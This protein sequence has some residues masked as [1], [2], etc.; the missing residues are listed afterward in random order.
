MILFKIV[1]MFFIIM[2]VYLTGQSTKRKISVLEA[3]C[4]RT[5]GFELLKELNVK[6]CIY[7]SKTNKS[8]E[9]AE[10]DCKGKGGFLVTLRTKEEHMLIALNA[11]NFASYVG[12]DEREKK[13][14]FVWH[15]DMSVIQDNDY[16]FN[17][18]VFD[19]DEQTLCCVLIALEEFDFRILPNV[20]TLVIPYV[21][22]IK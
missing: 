21:C 10:I 6:K 2:P 17:P 5:P 11:K 1:L 8:F 15:D 18:P 16:L 7:W 12:C 3:K 4:K 22:E 9:N 19:K 20:C 14:T 13:G